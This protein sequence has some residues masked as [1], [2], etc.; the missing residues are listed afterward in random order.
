M[1]YLYRKRFY[2]ILIFVFCASIVITRWAKLPIND[3]TYPPRSGVYGDA[4][5]DLNVLSAAQ[6]FKDFGFLRS[7]ALPVF[8]YK[9][10]KCLTG[11]YVYTHYPPLPDE[12]AGLFAMI[13]DSG[14]IKVLCLFPM[15]VSCFFFFF[16]FY[17][18]QKISVDKTA[19]FVS[20]TLTVT[21]CYFLCWADDLH[22]HVYGEFCKW[23]YVLL[24]FIYYEKEEKSNSL[25]LLLFVL[26]FINSYISYEHILYYGIV[27]VGFSLVYTRKLFC[28]ETVVLL[29][30]PV[31][32]YGT[33]MLQNH[34]LFRTWKGVLDDIRDQYMK[35]TQGVGDN[36]KMTSDKWGEIPDKIDT[37]F[38]RTFFI[39]TYSFLVLLF[40]GFRLLFRE[41]R[42]HF[43]IGIVL[44]LASSIWIFFMPEHVYFHLFTIKHFGLFYAFMLCSGLYGYWLVLKKHFEQRHKLFLS[45][46]SIFILYTVGMA[47]FS[48]VYYV[49]LKFGYGFPVLGINHNLY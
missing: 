26:G 44:F 23:I 48:Q 17:A 13:T 49:Y 33:H 38:T 2:L 34:F 4:W 29:A 9:G 18:L 25:L 42:K 5:S 3:P 45:L 16:I 11:T 10:D 40:F 43:Y 30:A 47:L 37:R 7:Y 39:N 35:R 19:A 46:H 22:Q 31:I 1:H 32:G 14:D 20:A 21:S 12:L 41:R 28:K 6:Q 27:T 8:A 36:F 24:M 15:L